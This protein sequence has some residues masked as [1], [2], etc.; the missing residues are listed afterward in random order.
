MGSSPPFPVYLGMLLA[1]AQSLRK[2]LRDMPAETASFFAG[3][4]LGYLP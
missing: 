2:K 1:F 4:L 3:C